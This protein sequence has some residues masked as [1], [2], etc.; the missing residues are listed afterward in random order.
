MNILINGY[1]GP[2]LTGIGNVLIHTVNAISKETPSAQLIIVTNYD[3]AELIE[4]LDANIL[5]RSIPISRNNT[6]LNLLFNIFI[7]PW[8]AFFKKIDIVY[9]SNFMM[10][11][12]KFKPTIVVIHDMIEFKVKKKFSRVR[13]AYRKVAVPSMARQ[14]THIITVSNNSKNDLI[15]ILNVN[16]AKISVVYNGIPKVKNITRDPINKSI[17]Q[18]CVDPY[19]LYIGTVDYP[20]KN[21]HA[22]ISAFAKYKMLG[23]AK[24]KF[25]LA[26][27]PGHGFDVIMNMISTNV[28]KNDITYLG[29]VSD[30]ERDYLYR[31]ASTFIY[32]SYYEG[33]GLPILE[34]MS[35]GTPVITSNRSCLP[36]IAGEAALIVDPDD[37]DTIAKEL[38]NL[39]ESQKLRMEYIR[40]GKIRAKDFCWIN[41]GQ[42]T[43]SI[44]QNIYTEGSIS[45]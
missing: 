18:S 5:V 30:L 2:Q 14:A 43:L 40:K 9:I 22:A 39:S 27:G 12:L 24:W 7:F 3:N 16:P 10:I 37:I 28:Y 44:F 34:A 19:L 35:H 15:N 20:G 21:I 8:I 29:Y 41:A 38:Q 23:G 4:K 32:L 45:I 42:K 13:T 11:L 26:G 25:V 33:F 1:V 36:E 6:F 17:V 31:H